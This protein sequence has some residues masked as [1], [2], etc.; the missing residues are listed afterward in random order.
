MNYKA[1]I[2]FITGTVLM[3]TQTLA[4]EWEYQLEP[5][6]MITSIKGDASVGRITGAEVDVDFNTI[7]DNLE[8]AAMLHFE[9]H[10]DSGWG[11]AF[12]YGYMDLGGKVRNDNGSSVNVE[13]HQG[14]LGAVD[15]SHW[16]PNNR[17]CQ[18]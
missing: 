4:D 14:V 15:L 13:V 9:A 1:L 2:S 8:S 11:L 12:D 6:V 10:H 7:L 16:Q 17:T 3:S 18:C 5:Y